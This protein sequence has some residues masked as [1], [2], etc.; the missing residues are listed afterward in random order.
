MAFERNTIIEILLDH[1]QHCVTRASDLPEIELESAC[2]M[3]GYSIPLLIC[4]KA[5][6]LSADLICLGLRSRSHF[7]RAAAVSVIATWSS[8]ITLQPILISKLI[9]SLDPGPS[10]TLFDVLAV[11]IQSKQA[12][13]CDPAVVDSVW[14]GLESDDALLSES[15]RCC[16][17]VM[18]HSSVG[19]SM[20]SAAPSTIISR[21][22]GVVRHC[23]ALGTGRGLCSALA[24][25]DL[26][27]YESTTLG[28]MYSKWC[29]TWIENI[30]LWLSA[31]STIDDPFAV[32]SKSRWIQVLDLI[33]SMFLKLLEVGPHLDSLFSRATT[34]TT[35]LLR[36]ALAQSAVSP[37][38][39]QLC[40]KFSKLL[41]SFPSRMRGP[42]LDDIVPFFRDCL[43]SV[44]VPVPTKVGI[45][46]NVGKLAPLHL[47][48]ASQIADWTFFD[49]LEPELQAARFAQAWEVRDSV[50]AVYARVLASC[51]I[52]GSSRRNIP[53]IIATGLKDTNESV[54]SNCLEALSS[55]ASVE[56]VWKCMLSSE[57]TLLFRIFCLPEDQ[58]GCRLAQMSG[59]GRLLRYPHVWT[60]IPDEPA[61]LSGF[62]ANIAHV[63]QD[64]DW[65]ARSS[66]VDVIESVLQMENP[67]R[68][69]LWRG[70]DCHRHLESLVQ[71]ES[72]LVR[73]RIW[74]LVLA[75]VSRPEIVILNFYPTLLG[76]DAI[77]CAL[78]ELEVEAT[79]DPDD[80]VYPL[81]PGVAD[82]DIDCP[83]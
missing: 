53:E 26:K 64:D 72:R 74:K 77:T 56:P 60:C 43:R 22:D 33:C 75:H 70:L 3:L 34:I 32:L 48:S 57:P 66:V 71:D 21:L 51:D 27:S 62:G 42:S 63:A 35:V 50:L 58:A 73:E 45:L 25:F 81:S 17:R 80:E 83:F 29:H 78:T 20:M 49:A 7:V 65:D 69:Q 79:Y 31:A 47:G 8:C 68:L 16:L 18:L 76:I 6:T 61:F 11:L 52:P 28:D 14:L 12:L 46:A 59:I 40:N 55:A 10:P 5:E 4:D 82:N 44:A 1:L 15:A 19:A 36:G 2:Q 67:Y 9:S 39:W 41:A 30:L 13:E 24:L 37:S 38:L 54:R 23:L